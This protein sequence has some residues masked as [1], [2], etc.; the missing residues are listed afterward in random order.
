VW[1]NPPKATSAMAPK[2]LK[3]TGVDTNDLH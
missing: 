2:V 1:I 3:I